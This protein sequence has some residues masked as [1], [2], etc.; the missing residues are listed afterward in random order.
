M[1]GLERVVNINIVNIP[2]RPTLE[3]DDLNSTN[4]SDNER[5]GERDVTHLNGRG[6][7]VES[8]DAGLEVQCPPHALARRGDLG[9]RQKGFLK[10]RCTCDMSLETGERTAQSRKAGFPSVQS[11]CCSLDDCPIR[12]SA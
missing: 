12:R 4:N 8:R 2:K 9:K 7:A 6:L 10:G 1:L 5:Q 11:D 3:I